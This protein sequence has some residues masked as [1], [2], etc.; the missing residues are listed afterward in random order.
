MREI[1]QYEK[2]N[3][4][5][6]RFV[7]NYRIVP[8]Y[9]IAAI[10][11]LAFICV[12]MSIDETK[13]TP[14]A[15][16]LF[17]FIGLLSALLLSSGP[18]VRKREIAE[19]MKRYDFETVG[20]K[21]NGT[22]DFSDNELSVHLDA[23]GMTINGLFFWYN[24]LRIFL[25]TGNKLNRIQIAVVF[26]MDEQNSVEIPLNGDTIDMIRKFHIQLENPDDLMYIVSHKKDAFNKIYKTGHV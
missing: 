3:M 16:A 7:M 4:N 2:D 22:Y 8:A 6:I 18:Y 9:V 5:K 11:C 17:V 13:Y 10:V 23:N 14:A 15:I 20:E 24:H 25:H 12:M 1:L 26:C 21:S 19:E